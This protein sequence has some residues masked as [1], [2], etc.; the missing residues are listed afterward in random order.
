MR[1]ERAVEIGQEAVGWLL[2]Q[3]DRL[4]ELMIASGATPQALPELVGDHE[5]LGFALDFLLGN[6]ATVIAFA[7][8]TGLR[9]E[10]PAQAR[11]VLTG[12]DGAD[13]T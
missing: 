5:F 6:D 11:A 8:A 3:P 12:P 4:M 1:L 7:S 10:E 2:L 9:P 13:W